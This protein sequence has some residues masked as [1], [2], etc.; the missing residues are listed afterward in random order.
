MQCMATYSKVLEK[1]GLPEPSL[2][3]SIS[4]NI[5]LKSNKAVQEK[6][7]IAELARQILATT[8][9]PGTSLFLS[10]LQ[11][12][13][14]CFSPSLSSKRQPDVSMFVPNKN[15]SFTFAHA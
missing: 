4:S 14:T 2:S 15:F 1:E 13:N 5:A 11:V 9:D 12:R 7:R 10:S 8:L 6:A 3:P